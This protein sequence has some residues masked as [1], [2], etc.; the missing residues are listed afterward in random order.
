MQ[1]KE[2]WDSKRAEIASFP[3]VTILAYED[4]LGM[5]HITSYTGD[6]K[7]EHLGWTT[8]LSSYIHVHVP[9]NRILPMVQNYTHKSRLRKHIA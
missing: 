5:V 7:A 3:G 4:L 1:G 8:Y 2:R 9:T 6:P